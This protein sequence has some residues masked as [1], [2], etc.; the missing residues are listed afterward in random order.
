M[1]PKREWTERHTEILDRMAGLYTDE[2]IGR[3]TGHAA[4]TVRV[5]RTIR[6]LPPCR[7]RDWTKRT[8]KLA[9]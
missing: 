4:I 3:V 8:W 5:R 1:K 9:A 6:G 2:E 7:R